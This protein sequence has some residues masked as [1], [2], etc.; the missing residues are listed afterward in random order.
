MVEHSSK[1]RREHV[2][3]AGVQAHRG[4]AFAPGAI[5]RRGPDLGGDGNDRHVPHPGITLESLHGHPAVARLLGNPRDN[6]ARPA[7]A[8]RAPASRYRR[9]WS[10]RIL[11]RTARRRRL[12]ASL[13]RRRPGRRAGG[14][15]TVAG[16]VQPFAPY[17]YLP[18]A[19]I[20]CPFPTQRARV[21]DTRDR[22]CSPDAT[23][24]RAECRLD[25]G[26]QDGS[27]PAEPGTNILVG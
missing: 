26:R 18:P 14:Q 1:A 10:H 11:W 19:V 3:G 17:T 16:E 20:V 9:W 4:A 15:A 24:V 7:A 12:R 25:G 23:G 2:R 8:A 6:D 22:P 5:A 27:Q 13:H 21:T